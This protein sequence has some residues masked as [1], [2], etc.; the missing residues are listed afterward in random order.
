[1]DTEQIR[2]RWLLTGIA[3]VLSACASNLPSVDGILIRSG[4]ETQLLSIR[5]DLRQDVSAAMVD[6]TGSMHCC[7]RT[8]SH[9]LLLGQSP[10][11]SLDGKPV[12]RYVIL[13]EGDLRNQQRSVTAGYLG[14]A[15]PAGANVR[16]KDRQTFLVT[17]D[18]DERQL[19]VC[20]SQEGV[21]IV[22]QTAKQGL[23][24]QHL[25]YELGYDVEPNCPPDILR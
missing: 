10:V 6:S 16:K 12:Y 3:L 15:V 8:A 13:L 18:K 20:L 1:M 17:A 19:T 21:H 23:P 5:Q 22:I 25:Y 11:S 4:G 7:L 14:V 9:A 24:S 2:W